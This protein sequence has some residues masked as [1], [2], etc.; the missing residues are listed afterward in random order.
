MSDD[1]R[2]IVDT[3]KEELGND[4]NHAQLLKL[5]DNY[6]PELDGGERMLVANIVTYE[7]Q[8]EIQDGVD[9][10]YIDCDVPI[11]HIFNDNYIQ[12][13]IA[14]AKKYEVNEFMA[15][16]KMINLLQTIVAGGFVITDFA[17]YAHTMYHTKCIYEEYGFRFLI[18]PK[19]F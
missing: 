4:Y 9:G 12:E 18:K 8:K 6:R 7:I 13:F 1:L 19:S 14:A 2:V 15:D 5:L 11:I 3:I 16:I 17:V 10:P